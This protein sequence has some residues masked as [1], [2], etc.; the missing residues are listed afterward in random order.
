MILIQKLEIWLDN[1]L[2]KYLSHMNIHSVYKLRHVFF[3]SFMQSSTLTIKIYY[4]SVAFCYLDLPFFYLG[5]KAVIS[6]KNKFFML[7]KF[8]MLLTMY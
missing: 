2:S 5:A 1:Q 4:F 3:L 7:V 8:K 6:Y